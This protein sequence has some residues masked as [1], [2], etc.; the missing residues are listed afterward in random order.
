MDGFRC[1]IDWMSS[2]RQNFIQYVPQNEMKVLI[3]F[4]VAVNVTNNIHSHT[5]KSRLDMLSSV[6]IIE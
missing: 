6:A 1:E 4:V 5:F 2:N 3:S